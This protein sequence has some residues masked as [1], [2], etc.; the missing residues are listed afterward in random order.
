MKDYKKILVP[1]DYSKLADL[2]FE[3]AISLATLVDGEV[4]ILHVIESY[5][6]YPMTLDNTEILSSLQTIELENKSKLEKMI[7]D[8]ISIGKDQGSK[9]NYMLKDGNVADTI[10]KESSNYDL[11]IMGTMGQNAIETL[12]L[13]SVA[14]KVSRHA[15]CP[16]MLVRELDKKCD[17][18]IK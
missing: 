4:T 14:E 9:V 7:T 17:T 11:I 12:L 15:C 8:I 2:A 18:N 10:I 16:V 5:P 1:Y 3:Q 6:Y 13:G